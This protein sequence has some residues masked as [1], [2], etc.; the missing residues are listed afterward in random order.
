MMAQYFQESKKEK[1]LS[2]SANKGERWVSLDIN[3]HCRVKGIK[4]SD[5][6]KTPEVWRK[7]VQQFQRL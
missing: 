2:N 4:K 3:S 5:N 7:A 6:K 1:V